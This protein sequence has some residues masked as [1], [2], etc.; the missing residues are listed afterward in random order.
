M[1][2]TIFG[3]VLGSIIAALIT[4]YIEVLRKPCLQLQVVPP[5]DMSFNGQPANRMRS[6]RVRL[7]NRPLP[8][9]VGWMYR[10]PALQCHG[11][12]TFHHLD[13]QNIFGRSM[14]LRWVRAPEP[15]PLR[16]QIGHEQGLV[17]DPV[18]ITHI[19]KMDIYPNE[20]EVIDIAARFDNEPECYGWSNESYFSVPLWR[21]PSWRIETGRYIVKVNVLSS[22]KT[23]SALFRLIND[24]GQ[25]DFR[26]EDALPTDSVRV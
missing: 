12:I 8:R 5:V 4:I 23:I 6:V 25:T 10:N 20:S 3:A 1:G 2:L 16:I 14:I 9:W 11:N 21:T 26:L 24:V 18:R 22:G 17:F 19:Q 7:I 15:N 13:G